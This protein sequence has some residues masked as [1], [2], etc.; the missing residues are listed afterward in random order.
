MS[1]SV[2]QHPLLWLTAA[3][4][5]GVSVE[6]VL[7]MFFFRQR[8]FDAESRAR[9]RSEELDSERF[10]HNRTQAELKNRAVEFESAQKGRTLAEALL[11]ATRGKLSAAETELHSLTAECA[12]RESE[13]SGLRRQIETAQA[14]IA[15][16]RSA[17]LDGELRLAEAQAAVATSQGVV[18]DLRS[19]LAQ[20]SSEL[21]DL[22]NHAEHLRQD[23]KDQ[24]IRIASLTEE[25]ESARRGESGWK[26]STDALREEVA[27]AR[28]ELKDEQENH[29]ALKSEYAALA[30]RLPKVESVSAAARAAAAVTEQKLKTRSEELRQ[31][32]TQ[33]GESTE[34]LATIKST[35]A[36]LQAN[37]VAVTAT[38]TSLERD[39]SMREQELAEAQA[40]L[41]AAPSV[42]T[43]DPGGLADLQEQLNA[44]QR[45][46]ASWRSKTEELESELL[47]T[48]RAHQGLVVEL[49]RLRFAPDGSSVDQSLVVELENM[50]RERN[51][52]AAELAALRSRPRG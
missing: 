17:G 26:D 11:L 37:L 47:A 20:I 8:L 44:E 9:K 32:A 16:R 45:A 36:Q 41:A 22:R 35:L 28:G 14:E 40:R 38:R 52:L 23:G 10:V 43:P 5:L 46:A 30:E 39:L 42:P 6:W 50:T 49:E 24:A 3:L 13:V 21:E 4:L 1:S 27:S 12:R 29:R 19:H 48:S 51:E 33:L 18:A 31:A 15:E 25:L 2:A 7:E 34:E